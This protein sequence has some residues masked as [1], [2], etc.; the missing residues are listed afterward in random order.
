MQPPEVD[1]GAKWRMVCEGPGMVGLRARTDMPPRTASTTP[2]RH[3]AI[4]AM[5]RSESVMEMCYEGGGT[6]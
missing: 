6:R 2:T 5:S 3:S 1:V 4:E